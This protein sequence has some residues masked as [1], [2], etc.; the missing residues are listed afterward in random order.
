MTS[1]LPWTKFQDFYLRLG[2]LKTLT[3]ALSR[4]RRSATNDAVIRKLE[5]PLFDSVSTHPELAIRTASLFAGTYPRKTSS[6]KQIDAPE[7]AEVLTAA[8]SGD[9]AL[10]GITRDTTYKMLDWGHDVDLVGRANQITERAL[11]LRSLLPRERTER[12]FSGEVSAWDPFQLDLR[13]RL[14]FT[15]HLI[16]IDLLTVELIADL[17]ALPSGRVL[18]SRDAAQMTCIAFFRIL[19]ATERTTEARYMAAHRTAL[20]LAI[21]MADEVEVAVPPE[22]EAHARRVR[23][24]RSQKAASRPALQVQR[25]SKPPRKTTKNADHQ[26]IPRF[27]QL[28]DLGFLSKPG[29]DAKDPVT[30]LAARRRWR[31]VP[32]DT[33]RRWARAAKNVADPTVAFRWSSFAKVAVDAFHGHE[34]KGPTATSTKEMGER[35][36]NA[37]SAVGRPV[38]LSPAD[39]ITL[40]ATIDAVVDGAAIEMRDFHNFLLTIKEHDLLP[41]SISFGAGAALDTM[42]IRIKPNFLPHLTEVLDQFPAEFSR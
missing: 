32:T 36:W 31:Y 35:I 29:V 37:Y 28:V 7:V 16:E 42:F 41:E 33:C 40:R 22:W 12:F 27:E 17:G 18:E 6:G 34:R 30:A 21:T 20:E 15:F 26:T 38:G 3:A 13:E 19:K 11:V 10:Y 5:R 24:M 4:E 14:F 8:G 23:A 39:S 2:F 25:T 9:S 1:R